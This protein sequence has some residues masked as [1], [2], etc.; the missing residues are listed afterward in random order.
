[1]PTLS[2]GQYM[3][4]LI[5]LGTKNCSSSGLPIK[6][7]EYYLSC[8]TIRACFGMAS[9]KLKVNVK[10]MYI[11]VIILTPFSKAPTLLF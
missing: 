8:T 9:R 1:M 2:L 11:K 3:A 6:K 4:E 7:K 5:I 10:Y